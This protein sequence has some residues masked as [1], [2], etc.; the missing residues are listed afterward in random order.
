MIKFH[1]IIS[2]GKWNWLVL[3]MFNQLFNIENVPVS[4][5]ALAQTS[6]NNL[7]HWTLL[8]KFLFLSLGNVTLKIT[9]GFSRV[10]LLPS[11]FFYSVFTSLWMIIIKFSRV[12]RI[13]ENGVCFIKSLLWAQ[14]LEQ[15]WQTIVSN[16]LRNCLE[17]TFVVESI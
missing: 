12:T 8:R 15:R 6:W 16:L 11:C 5:D 17:I 2:L 10:F 4:M 3:F 7:K 1:T 9:C 14:R 13:S